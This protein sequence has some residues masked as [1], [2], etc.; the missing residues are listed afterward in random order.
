MIRT[1]AASLAWPA[2]ALRSSVSPGIRIFMYHR[3]LPVAGGDQLCVS[4]ARFERQIAWLGANGTPLRLSEVPAILSGA[5]P[6]PYRAFVVT[7]D[8][9]YL[10]NLVHALPVLRRHGIP[11]T[12]FVTTEFASQ[13]ATHPRYSSSADRVHLDWD[14]VRRL[15]DEG[16]V[17]IG[18]HTCTH[19]FLRRLDDRTAAYEISESARRIQDETGRRAG[20]FCYPSGDFGVREEALVRAAGYDGAV[21]VAPGSN[22]QG[23][24]LSR[25]QRTELTDEDDEFELRLKCAGAFDPF[26]RILHRRRDARFARLAEDAR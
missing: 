25:L 8:D 9:G 11:A 15:L 20:W 17:D 2:M 22:D 10:D 13:R 7:F 23:S 26:H 14:E 1:L 3:I 19:P 6:M 21:S 12:I 24:V 18:S 4:V 5:V 16:L